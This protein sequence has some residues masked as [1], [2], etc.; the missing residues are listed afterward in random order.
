MSKYINVSTPKQVEWHRNKAVIEY[1]IS[2]VGSSYFGYCDYNRYLLIKRATGNYK[3]WGFPVASKWKADWGDPSWNLSSQQYVT[4]KP[5]RYQGELFE[6]RT[7]RDEIPIT[8]TN[9][10]QDSLEITVGVYAG[11][12][13]NSNFGTTTKTIK[14]YTTKIADASN[15]WIKSQVDSES[16]DGREIIVEGGFTNPENYYTMKLYKNGVQVPF[17]GT[18][19]EVLEDNTEFKTLT[20]ELRIY[21]KDGTYYKELT[22]T[23]ILNVEPLGPGVSVNNSGTIAN[24]NAMYL[25]N[26]SHKNITEVWIKKDGNVHKTVK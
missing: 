25:N 15:V 22:K 6:T 13:I 2:K 8:R 26:V 9:S 4:N 18:Y 17:N 3:Y 10:R 21:G 12:G 19:T 7:F 1:T 23:S 11:S 16:S 5:G 24:V 20:F 14:V